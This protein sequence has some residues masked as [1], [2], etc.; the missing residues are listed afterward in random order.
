MNHHL[1]IRVRGLVQGVFFLAETQREAQEHGVTGFVR[2]EPDGSV[3]IEAEA[4]EHTLKNFVT[5]CH[6]GSPRSKVT[7]VET[8]PGALQGF[9]EFEIRY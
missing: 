1:N 7:A 2:N 4:E 9:E 3:Y 6:E 8:S 5:W